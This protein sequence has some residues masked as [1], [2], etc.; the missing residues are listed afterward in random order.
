MGR[1]TKLNSKICKSL[2]ES[3]ERGMP[4]VLACQKAGIHFDTFNE[5][6]K[7]GEAEDIENNV[8]AEFSERIRRSEA[9]CADR[10]LERIQAR[11]E[12]G[13]SVNDM[14]LLERRYSEHF[15]RKD[16]MDMKSDMKGSVK[17]EL[18]QE[19]CGQDSE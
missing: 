11:A 9:I 17:I 6:M 12:E 1:H 8:Y 19:D 4:Y 14:W 3:I 13:N 16:K 5:W 10:C 7:K 2:C 15:G 18:K